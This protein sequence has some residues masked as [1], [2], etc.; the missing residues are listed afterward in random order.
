MKLTRIKIEGT[1]S[2]G[3]NICTSGI[4]DDNI[5]VLNKLKFPCFNPKCKKGFVI[6]IQ[7]I[8]KYR[9]KIN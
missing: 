6:M 9:E 7:E 8:T 5:P 1:C 2:C 4:P 3:A